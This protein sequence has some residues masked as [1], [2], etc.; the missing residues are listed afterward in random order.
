MLFSLRLSQ[1]NSEV[2][3]FKLLGDPV[4]NAGEYVINLQQPKK[5]YT[6]TGTGETF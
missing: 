2:T 1:H 5:H 6:D 3:V 4:G